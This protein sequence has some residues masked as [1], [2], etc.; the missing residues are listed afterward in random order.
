MG[1]AMFGDCHPE[2]IHVRWFEQ[3]KESASQFERRT[4]LAWETTELPE[5]T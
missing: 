4:R 3:S 1:S 2:G 5:R